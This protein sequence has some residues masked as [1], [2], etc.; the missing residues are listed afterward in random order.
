[1]TE[2]PERHRPLKPLTLNILL[3]LGE[4]AHHGYSLM[5]LLREDSRFTA[6]VHTGPLYRALK[7]LLEI[8]FVVEQ[9]TPPAGV[10]GDTRRGSYYALSML[11]RRVLAAELD[12]LA[13]VVEMG[14]QL[15]LAKEGRS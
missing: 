2:N 1:M 15:G 11:G 9:D 7:H 14:Q 8:G 12:R 10:E 5:R 6:P 13:G 4:R 3:A